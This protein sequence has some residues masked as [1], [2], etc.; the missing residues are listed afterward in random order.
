FGPDPLDLLEG[1][2]LLPRVADHPGVEL[3]GALPGLPPLEVADGVRAAGDGLEGPE[4]VE[5]AGLRV[6]HAAPVHG[7]R[8]L[9]HDHPG[10]AAGLRAGQVVDE[11]AVL[12]AERVARVRI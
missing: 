9:L 8:R 12:G 7:P 10:P 1:A 11:R 4:P 2:A 3:L 6:V 5:S